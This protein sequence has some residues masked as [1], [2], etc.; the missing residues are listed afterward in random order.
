MENSFVCSEET[1]SKGRPKM[2][3]TRKFYGF[4]ATPEN[5]TYLERMKNQGVP[6]TDVL[7]SALKLWRESR[8]EI[9]R[10]F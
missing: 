6:I 5:G 1:N 10:L 4:R 3:E 9:K 7:N 8:R 2:E